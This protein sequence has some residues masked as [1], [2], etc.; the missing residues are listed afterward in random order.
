MQVMTGTIAASDF[1]ASLWSVTRKTNG[2]IVLQER[3]VLDVD[4][5]GIFL[6]QLLDNETLNPTPIFPVTRGIS[7]SKL[8]A[9]VISCNLTP[10]SGGYHYSMTVKTN[11]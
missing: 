8:P 9:M 6:R 11:S 7:L 1:D 2:P 5:S 4:A 3:M 10:W